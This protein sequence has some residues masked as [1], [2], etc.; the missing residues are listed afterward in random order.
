MIVA[1]TSPLT[2]IDPEMGAPGMS[3]QRCEGYEWMKSL[4]SLEQLPKLSDAYFNKKPVMV[5][6]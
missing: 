2:Y 4:F 1:D 3:L 5:N 6:S